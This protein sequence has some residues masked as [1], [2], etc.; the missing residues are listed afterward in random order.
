M[1]SRANQQATN[2]TSDAFV[3]CP[4]HGD[5]FWDPGARS[6]DPIEA[7]RMQVYTDLP[8]TGSPRSGDETVCPVIG[9]D[10]VVCRQPL[11][12]EVRPKVKRVGNGS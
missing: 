7:V 3:V 1:A 5:I 10:A 4:V 9:A 2:V 8:I 6:G 11:R 12:F